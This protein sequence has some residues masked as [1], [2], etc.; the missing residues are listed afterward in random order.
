MHE[1]LKSHLSRCMDV[2][3]SATR[4]QSHRHANRQCNTCGQF[5]SSVSRY[6]IHNSLTPTLKESEC[7]KPCISG[8]RDYG[9]KENPLSYMPRRV[10]EAFAM[11][12]IRD[13]RKKSIFIE[14]AACWTVSYRY[15]HLRC[16]SRDERL[17]LGQ[18]HILYSHRPLADRT[19]LSVSSRYL[20]SISRSR[21]FLEFGLLDSVPDTCSFSST[22]RTS[23][24]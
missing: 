23:R 12:Y 19:G 22:V 8:E 24:R 21:F 16:V 20:I 15:Q 11:L 6:L 17:Q 7:N 3:L 4:L 13:C 5:Q 10:I 18:P 14:V 1:P 2:G 9:I